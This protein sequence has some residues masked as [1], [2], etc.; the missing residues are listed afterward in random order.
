MPLINSFIVFAFEVECYQVVEIGS[1]KTEIIIHEIAQFF[2]KV[3]DSLCKYFPSLS[4]D[5]IF[6]LD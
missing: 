2:K 5:L 6:L 4:L 1:S 3:G